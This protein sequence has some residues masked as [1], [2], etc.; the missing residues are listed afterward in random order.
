MT[1]ADAKALIDRGY[2]WWDDQHTLLLIPVRCLDEI[3]DGTTLTAIDGE[4]VVKGRDEI[5]TDT[6]GGLLAYGLP[7]EDA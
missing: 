7:V 4:E 5:D 3:A 2:R 1:R 6:R